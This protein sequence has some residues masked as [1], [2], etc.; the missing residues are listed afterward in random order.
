MSSTPLQD[1]Y[2]VLGVTGSI[3]AY[4]AADLASKLTQAGARVDTVLTEAA[5]RF[6]SPLTFQSVTGRPAYTDADLWGAQAHVLHVGLGHTADLLVIAPATAQ[7]MAKLAH[8]LADNL[9]TLAAL[10]AACPV[11]IAPAMDGGM[12]GQAAT[13]ANVRILQERGMAIVG[14]EEGHLASGLKARGRMTE[15]VDLVGHIR[16]RLSRGGPLAGR[17]VIVTA[18]GTQEPVDPVRVLTN[19]SSGKQGLALAQAALDAGADVTLIAASIAL[20]VPIGLRHVPVGTAAEMA[21]AVLDACREADVL[22]MAAAVADFTPADPAGHK[23]KKDEGLPVL[24]LKRTA[25]ILSEVA[26]QRQATGRPLVVAGFAAETQNLLANARAKLEAKRLDLMVA[27]DV[28]A[29]DAGFSVDTNR[30]TLIDADGAEEL[31]LMS[32]ADVAERVLQRVTQLIHD[33]SLTG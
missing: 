21:A 16:Y 7:T 30:V 3:A 1:K 5:T 18:G 17:Q 11:L 26:R 24:A 33:A 22:L 19:R 8:G 15:P 31:A 6:V 20:P 12:F 23:I 25:D 29:A 9:L 2:I 14:P 10:A 27:N 4:K 28:S 32:K 13:Q